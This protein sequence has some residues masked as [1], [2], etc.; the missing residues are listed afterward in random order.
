MFTWSCSYLA[1]VATA[2]A[3][4]VGFYIM[5][6]SRR[7]VQSYVSQSRTRDWNARA[8][9]IAENNEIFFHP[10]PDSRCPGRHLVLGSNICML[11]YNSHY[12]QGNVFSQSPEGY[13]YIHHDKRKYHQVYSYK[14]DELRGLVFK[15]EDPSFM[16]QYDR[17]M[18]EE[19]FVYSIRKFS[20]DGE[21]G[22]WFEIESPGNTQQMVIESGYDVQLPAED[23]Q[24]FSL[25]RRGITTRIT[26]SAPQ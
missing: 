19:W 10:H 20:V 23:S 12:K 16:D 1:A 5:H 15:R 13:I 3:I 9:R 2:A 11:I 18:V 26:I 25:E 8:V 7:L 21:H 4:V 17:A 24:I 22:R 6:V 14:F